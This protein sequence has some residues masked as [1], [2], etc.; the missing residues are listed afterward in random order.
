MKAE[1]KNRSGRTLPAVIAALGLLGGTVGTATAAGTIG[2]SF[3]DGFPVIMDHSLN[4][5]LAGFGAAGPVTRTPVIFLHGNNDTAHPTICNPYGD[6]H[7]FAQYL[8]DQGYQPSELWGLNYLGDQCDLLSD[9][10]HRSSEAHTIEANVPDLRN[11]VQAVLDYTGAK[12][13]D[14]VA[15][16]MGAVLAREWLRQDHAYKLVRRV[17]SVDGAHQGINSCSP[18]P[19][20]HYQLPAFGGFTPDSPL[21]KELG[22][23]N[24]PLL[25]ELNRKKNTPGQTRFLA[26]RNADASFVY[27]P[28]FDGY[29]PPIPSEDRDGNAFDFSQS[30]RLTDALN[31]DVVGQGKY[32]PILATAHIGIFNSPEVWKITFDYLTG[33]Q[34]KQR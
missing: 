23:P 7:S 1:H 9:Q 3:P 33:A 30:A 25:S 10:T 4:Q 26:I 12:Q 24:T 5:P 17:V 22:S 15:H 31:V 18:N 34:P 8:S 28:V 21:C 20:N 27:M 6:A 19:L 11:F 16:S 29:M 2:M 13:V 32:D 14:I